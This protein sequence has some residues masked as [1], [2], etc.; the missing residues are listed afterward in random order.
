MFLLHSIEMV[1][2]FNAGIVLAIVTMASPVLVYFVL[3]GLPS[4]TAI[5]QISGIP[6]LHMVERAGSQVQN[7]N[8]GYL[9][10]IDFKNGNPEERLRIAYEHSA[11]S[12]VD[13]CLGN[14]P[15][16]DMCEDTMTLLINSCADSSMHVAACD[17]PRLTNY[18]TTNLKN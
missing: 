8:L 18:R 3:A 1:D 15:N 2:E 5:N 6:E 10:S 7:N 9:N 16:K 12:E 11:Q 13:R 4:A 17:D 14:S